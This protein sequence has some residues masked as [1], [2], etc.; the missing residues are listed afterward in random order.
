[1]E[2]SRLCSEQPKKWHKFVPPLLFAYREAPQRFTGFS[3]LRIVIWP[4]GESPI[5]NLELWTGNIA[6]NKVRNTYQ[7][8][9]ELQDRIQDTL[10]IARERILQAQEKQKHYYDPRNRP[11][12]LDKVLILLPTSHNKMLMFWDGPHKVVS[13][14]R[15][16]NFKVQ[17]EKRLKLITLTY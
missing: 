17:C 12:K 1:M 2:L 14:G 4:H 9:F 11:R 16:N 13:L 7:Y 5:T 15:N 6:P 3:P 8:V 10:R